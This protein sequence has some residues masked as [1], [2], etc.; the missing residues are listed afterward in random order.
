M[1]VAQCA[2]RFMIQTG[3]VGMDSKRERVSRA[4]FGLLTGASEVLV[5][6]DPST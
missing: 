3:I 2:H 5:D 1:S 4:A 6:A